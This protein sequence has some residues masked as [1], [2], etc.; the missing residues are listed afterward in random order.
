MN[1][2]KTNRIDLSNRVQYVHFINIMNCDLST[3]R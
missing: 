1:V 3:T 2:L